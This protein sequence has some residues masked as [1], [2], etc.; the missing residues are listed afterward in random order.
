MLAHRRMVRDNGLSAVPCIRPGQSRK[1]SLAVQGEFPHGSAQR[2]LSLRLSCVGFRR[3]PEGCPDGVSR[4]FAGYLFNAAMTGAVEEH[5]ESPRPRPAARKRRKGMSGH[6]CF[7]I[8]PANVM[9]WRWDTKIVVSSFVAGLS[10]NPCCRPV[11]FPRLCS[12]RRPLAAC[13]H[14]TSLT[15]LFRAFRAASCSAHRI[16]T[17]FMPPKPASSARGFPATFRLVCRACSP[18]PGVVKILYTNVE[19]RVNKNLQKHKYEVKQ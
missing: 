3:T 7:R 15:G 1:G 16:A 4:V 17:A 9:R 10:R 2:P 18:S 5:R 8:L 14:I 11:A 12:A 6:G 19:H 13:L